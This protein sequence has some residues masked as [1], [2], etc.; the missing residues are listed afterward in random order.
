[1]PVS[2][3]GEVSME[4]IVAKL[5]CLPLGPSCGPNVPIVQK[6]LDEI[7]WGALKRARIL[8]WMCWMSTMAGPD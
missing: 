3:G 5:R 2:G 1:M 4:E 7:A 6:D 8:F